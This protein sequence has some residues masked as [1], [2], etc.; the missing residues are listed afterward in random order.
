MSE[1]CKTA[2]TGVQESDPKRRRVEEEEE[3]EEEQPG[4]SGLLERMYA[5]IL[6]AY[7]GTPAEEIDEQHITEQLDQYFREPLIDRQT[8]RMVETECIP[9]IPSCTTCKKIPLSTAL[10]CSQRE[11]IQ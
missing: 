6:G 3:E 11:N 8:T 4:P 10:L 1:Q 9:P 2:T 5:N 7:G